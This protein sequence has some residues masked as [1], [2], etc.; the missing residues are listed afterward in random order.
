MADRLAPVIPLNPHRRLP[1]PHCDAVLR[2]PEL[3][4]HIDHTCPVLTAKRGV[5]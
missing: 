3:V 4:V 5:S 1:C 2:I